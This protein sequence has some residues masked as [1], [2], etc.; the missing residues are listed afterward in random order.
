MSQTN[1]I[2]AS[3]ETPVVLDGAMGTEL[4]KR[5]VKTND[6][7]WSANA[8][9]TDPDAIYDVHASYFRA[10]AE[11]AITDTYQANVAAFAKVGIEK[12]AA[13]DLIRLGVRLAQQ[14]RDN[15][16]PD[17]LVAGCV[18]PYGAYLA[19]GSEY[20]GDYQLS[21]D[22]YEAFHT[23][24][25]QTLMDAGVDLLSV[26]TI[27]SFAEVQAL[28]TILAQQS[29][30][31]PTWISLSIKDPYHLSDG[32]PLDVVAGWLDHSQAASGIGINCTSFANVLPALKLMR[33]VTQKPLVVYPNPGDIYDPA[34]KTWTAVEHPQTFADVVPD[35]L[36]ASA[37]IIGGCCRTTPAD[38]EQI[39]K[40]LKK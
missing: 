27:P 35:W 12:E 4:E 26:D 31:V 20:T 39:A 21:P 11:I 16:K 8:P 25:I 23:E 37:N 33:Q 36:A 30:L 40:L 1:L 15:V 10:G 7:L 17:G 32:T 18:G 28:T 13:L 34:T 5:G 38:I 14:A 2:T 22:E 6:A 19:D 3:L 29:N 9:L 24:K